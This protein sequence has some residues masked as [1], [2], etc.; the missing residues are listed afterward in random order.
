[1]PKGLNLMAIIRLTVDDALYAQRDFSGMLL[2]NEEAADCDG[3][4][5]D[6]RPE[7]S[8]P[9]EAYRRYVARHGDR[10]P[11]GPHEHLVMAMRNH[12]DA[13]RYKFYVEAQSGLRL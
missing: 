2:H 13:K 8:L 10:P 6:A 12:P 11:I 5:C 3:E 7:L 4:E 1:M 9:A